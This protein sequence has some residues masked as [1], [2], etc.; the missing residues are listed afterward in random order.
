M[1]LFGGTSI[2]A[3]DNELY[4]LDYTTKTWIKYPK[5]G[6]VPY[7]R[8]AALIS[9]SDGV[10]YIFGGEIIKNEDGVLPDNELYA[11][12]LEEQTWKVIE[13]KGDKPITRYL[14]SSGVYNGYLYVFYGYNDELEI[15]IDDFSRISLGTFEWESLEIDRSSEYYDWFPRDAYGLA[16]HQDSIVIFG[17]WTYLGLSN[18]LLKAS[19]VTSTQNSP[20][21]RFD[22]KLNNQLVPSPRSHHTMVPIGHKLY[23][24]GGENSGNL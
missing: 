17:G 9:Y 24:F 16:L 1:M 21:I 10:I 14:G 13:T 18:I 5:R 6:Q 22:I 11:Y 23:L 12:Y 4:E 8:S 3:L 15:D 20:V 2:S 19:L 7:P